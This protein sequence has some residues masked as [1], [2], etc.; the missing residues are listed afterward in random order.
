[1]IVAFFG[2]SNYVEGQNDE[3]NL[4]NTL[5]EYAKNK[6]VEFYLGGYG[7]FDNFA[8]RC[9]NKYKMINE[10][11]TTIYVS[12]YLTA[13]TKLTIAKENYDEIIY[14]PIEAVP[15]K[16]AIT[17]RNEWIVSVADLIVFNVN[18]KFGGAYNAYLHAKRKGKLIVDFK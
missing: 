10:N 12:P 11:A 6:K 3:K 8:L 5:S 14:P 1:M 9:C 7:N 16:Y 13:F 4:I 18:Y 17:K 15:Q 2:H